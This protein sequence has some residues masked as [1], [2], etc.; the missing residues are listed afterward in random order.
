MMATASKTV[1]PLVASEISGGDIGGELR[2][3]RKGSDRDRG[4]ISCSDTS[5]SSISALSGSCSIEK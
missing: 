3:D 5:D 4:R 1:A 2:G